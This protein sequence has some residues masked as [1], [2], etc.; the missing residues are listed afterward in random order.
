MRG[1]GDIGSQSFWQ[2][3]KEKSRRSKKTTAGDE[4]YVHCEEMVRRTRTKSTLVLVLQVQEDTMRQA[5]RQQEVQGVQS[6]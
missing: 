5:T 2:T 4:C 6:T 1:E 3:G